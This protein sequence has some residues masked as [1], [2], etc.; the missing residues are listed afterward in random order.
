MK[1]RDAVLLVLLVVVWGTLLL[2]VIAASAA[3][4]FCG[5]SHLCDSWREI[6]ASR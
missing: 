4:T 3:D 1:R 2:P 6:E 5:V